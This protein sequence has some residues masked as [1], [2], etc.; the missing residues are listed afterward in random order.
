MSVLYNTGFLI[1]TQRITCSKGAKSRFFSTLHS[2][3][4]R[5]KSS[6]QSR[7]APNREPPG[8][9]SAEVP[10][11]PFYKMASTAADLNWA[12]APPRLRQST[13]P[14]VS[15][16]GLRL[17]HQATRRP[18]WKSICCSLEHMALWAFFEIDKCSSE[19]KRYY[20]LFRPQSWKDLFGKFRTYLRKLN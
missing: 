8:A 16:A 9:L 3:T 17:P 12:P 10:T 7:D 4:W 5:M 15:A 6:R 11:C 19:P 13:A 14:P 18:F 2:R 1:S 20:T